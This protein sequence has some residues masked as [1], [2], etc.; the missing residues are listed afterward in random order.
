[1]P[2]A[3][4]YLPSIKM[5]SFCNSYGCYLL[6]PLRVS[7]VTP[8]MNDVFATAFSCA[9]ISGYTDYLDSTCASKHVAGLA[10]YTGEYTLA[11]VLGNTSCASKDI[12]NNVLLPS[13]Q[14]VHDFC[15]ATNGICSSTYPS[16]PPCIN[17]VLTNSSG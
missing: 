6:T 13:F 7:E 15:A 11:S 9:G 16:S 4:L 1:M 12:P 8:T 17:S 14:A 5:S 10:R 2:F 3:Q